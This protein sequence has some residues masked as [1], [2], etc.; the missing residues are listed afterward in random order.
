MKYAI[1]SVSAV[2]IVSILAIII[3]MFLRSQKGN[4]DI[5]VISQAKFDTIMRMYY[6]GLKIVDVAVIVL[7]ASVVIGTVLGFLYMIKH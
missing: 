4:I 6:V 2:A 3:G 5:S 7:L 1:R